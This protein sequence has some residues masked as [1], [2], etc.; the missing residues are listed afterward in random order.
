[1][2]HIS[3][4]YFGTPCTEQSAYYWIMLLYLKTIIRSN[5]T[6][7]IYSL[8][9]SF[10]ALKSYKHMLLLSSEKWN[11]SVGNNFWSLLPYQAY[12]TM[13]HHSNSAS[14]SFWIYPLNNY[15]EITIRQLDSCILSLSPHSVARSRKHG[16][17]IYVCIVII[18]KSVH[19]SKAKRFTELFCARAPVHQT[20]LCIAFLIRYIWDGIHSLYP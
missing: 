8:P 18:F 11:M 7:Q 14:R 19:G 9:P 5:S 15:T 6:T 17:Y 13:N 3:S 4:S 20:I 10:V 2:Q 12:C 16:I 1:M